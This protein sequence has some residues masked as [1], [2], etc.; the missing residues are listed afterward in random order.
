MSAETRDPLGRIVA[1][2]RRPNT[3]HE[4][5][6][7]TALDCPVGIG[8]IVR[9]EGS[10]PVEGR[11]PRVYGIVVEGFSYTDLQSPMHDVLGH[12]GSP[13]HA[14]FA[15]TERAEIR[16][17]TAATEPLL[18]GKCAK[19]DWR[20][21]STAL[22]FVARPETPVMLRCAASGPSKKSASR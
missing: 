14:P 8:T 1:T 19:I 18:A 9:V 6:F 20:S 15:A 21:H 3:P 13:A 10:V 17:Y 12:D 16:L 5:H 11:L 4:F 22:V 2:E 7:W